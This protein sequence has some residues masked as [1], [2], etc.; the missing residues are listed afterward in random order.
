[1]KSRCFLE[2]LRHSRSRAALSRFA[3]LL[4]VFATAVAVAGWV[5]RVPNTPPLD[6]EAYVWQRAWNEELGNAVIEAGTGLAG[7]LCLAGE[8]AVENG[9]FKTLRIPINHLAL[10]QAGDKPTAV[11]R[12]F[13]SVAAGGWTP[14]ARESCDGLLREIVEEWSREH[15]GGVALQIDFDCPES[16]LVEFHEQ[17]RRWKAQFPL[18]PI[19]FTALPTWLHRAEFCPLAAEFPDYVLQVHSLH[20]P[21][22]TG[23]WVGLCDPSE[24][25]TAT[26]AAAKLGVPFRLALPTYSCLVVFGENGK[27]AEVYGEDL[28]ETLPVGALDTIALDSDAHLLSSMVREWERARPE[29]MRGIV[30]YRLPAPGDRLNWDWTLLE[31]VIGGLPLTRSWSLRAEPDPAGYHRIVLCNDGDAPDDLPLRFRLRVPG[32]SVSGSD[33]LAGYVSTALP[34][35]AA[36]PEASFEWHLVEPLREFQKP[37]GWSGVVGW[38]RW[39]GGDAPPVSEF[40]H[41]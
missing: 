32:A 15:V 34:N 41:Y 40:S 9:N 19:T 38:C 39:Q 36:L 20:L 4:G 8:I 11:V 35:A 1:M 16:R 24:M 25:R 30:W 5:V 17:M 28:P 3:C 23:G 12:I 14:Q 31:R 6:H 13:P 26:H 18:V 27:V 37:P 33:G 10:R 7:L 2:E 22:K 29:S 21:G